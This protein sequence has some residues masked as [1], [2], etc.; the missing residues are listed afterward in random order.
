[1]AKYIH[2]DLVKII[3]SD[4]KKIK[5][6]NEELKNSDIANTLSTFFGWRHF[7]ELQSNVEK[8]SI[9]YNKKLS[10][11]KNM[12]Y[13]ELDSF[14]T[15][16][17]T[18][19]NTNFYK[20]IKNE[21]EK[22]IYDPFN[23]KSGIFGRLKNKKITFLKKTE[24]SFILDISLL[25][26][27]TYIKLN[28]QNT[29]DLIKILMENM[30]NKSANGMWAGRTNFFTNACIDAFEKDKNEINY[31]SKISEFFEFYNLVSY[32][33]NHDYR[34]QCVDL[35]NYIYNMPG[36]REGVYDERSCKEQNGFIV[37]QLYILKQSFLNPDV[38]NKETI[39][40]NE[41]R[42]FKGSIRVTHL[43]TG[44]IENDLKILSRLL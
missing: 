17:I 1:M 2:T 34:H 32:F 8:E 25:R 14:K 40:L 41:L 27:E 24:G 23:I 28:N 7:N 20:D 36:Y 39:N 6:H 16:Y 37:M 43:D 19:I 21:D 30:L 4:V 13:D 9:L 29:E 31:Q 10:Q 33:E 15:K 3:K 5:A 44:E 35:A 42:S 11:I 18:F 12:A 38:R 26:G 22:Y